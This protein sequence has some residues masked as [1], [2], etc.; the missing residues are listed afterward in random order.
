MLECATSYAFCDISR[1]V[2]GEASL[3]M[4]REYYAVFLTKKIKLCCIICK[5]EN[6]AISDTYMQGVE[7]NL[8]AEID[9]NCL[10]LVL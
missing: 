3:F 6:D 9:M 2:Q 5:I 10:C 7:M 4:I 8:C 1:G